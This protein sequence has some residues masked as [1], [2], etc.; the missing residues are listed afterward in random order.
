M[1]VPNDYPRHYCLTQY[2]IASFATSTSRHIQT[3]TTEI[4]GRERL[5]AC[6]R[7]LGRDDKHGVEYSA[8]PSCSYERNSSPKIPVVYVDLGSSPTLTLSIFCVCV[9]SAWRILLIFIS[10]RNATKEARQWLR[11]ELLCLTILSGD[12]D[13]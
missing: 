8:G 9:C 13:M 1:F 7:P 12:G 2:H 3:S 4:A 11:G 10:V 5:V 6:P